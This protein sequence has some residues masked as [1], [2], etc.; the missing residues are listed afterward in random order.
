M[1]IPIVILPAPT[2]NSVNASAVAEL[3]S[4]VSADK[5]DDFWM[6]F[7]EEE[8][9][10]GPIPEMSRMNVGGTR[11]GQLGLPPRYDDGNGPMYRQE[12]RGSIPMGITM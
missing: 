6:V 7:V 2:P 1:I 12:R 3:N 9:V 4:L 8:G 11:Q 10:S 5:A